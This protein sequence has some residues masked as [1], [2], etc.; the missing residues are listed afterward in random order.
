[1]GASKVGRKARRV[2]TVETVADDAPAP[3]LAFPADGTIEFGR[4]GELA[5]ANLPH[6]TPDLDM[7]AAAFRIVR[8]GRL[9]GGDVETHFVN[10]C[11]NWRQTRG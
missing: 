4:W 8:K 5:R 7:V 2:G 9:R 6:P 11:K 10:F 1:M 3:P